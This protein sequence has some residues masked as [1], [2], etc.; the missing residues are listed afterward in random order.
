MV[1]KTRTPNHS[2]RHLLKDRAYAELKDRILRG[3]CEPGTFLSERQIV[4]WLRMSKTPI[5]AALEKLETEGLVRVSPQQGILVRE[6]SIHDIADQFELRAALETYVVRHLAGRLTP[7]QA[8]Q[9]EANL[10]AQE[11]ALREHELAP[12]VTLD[13]E[14]HILFSRFL[15]NR[16][17]IEVMERLRGKIHRVILRVNEQHPDRLAVSVAEHRGIASAV[18]DGDAALAARRVEE[19]LEL[20]KQYLLSPRR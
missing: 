19:H 13:A 7:D 8:G 2:R 12:M 4:G 17:I 5:R 15:G 10:A 11:R 3:D 18:I 9:L 14:F 1:T 20:G 6:L 16:E